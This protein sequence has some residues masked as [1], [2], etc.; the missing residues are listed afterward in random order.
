[1]MM[2]NIPVDFS[3]ENEMSKKLNGI[4]FMKNW[5]YKPLAVCKHIPVHYMKF[6]HSMSA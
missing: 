2:K 3:L 6:H 1:M 5:T 4:I